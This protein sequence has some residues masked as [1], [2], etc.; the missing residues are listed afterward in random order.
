MHVAYHVNSDV[1]AYRFRRFT[2]DKFCVTR[3]IYV[4]EEKFV[5]ETEVKNLIARHLIILAIKPGKSGNCGKKVGR[6]YRLFH[7]KSISFQTKT[8]TKLRRRQHYYANEIWGKE[9]VFAENEADR[10][11]QETL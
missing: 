1:I 8:T 2:I 9:K 3:R 7:T 4:Y 10:I 11:L 6:N 5:A